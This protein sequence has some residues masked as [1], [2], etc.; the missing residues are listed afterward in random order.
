MVLVRFV[1]G[2]LLASTSQF[3]L[4]TVPVLPAPPLA[5]VESR[6]LIGMNPEQVVSVLGRPHSDISNNVSRAFE[7]EGKDCSRTVFFKKIDG[8]TWSVGSYLGF[9]ENLK[10]IDP[11]KCLQQ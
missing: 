1:T 3:S 9:D 8:K 6:R 11:S 4:P 10:P 5:S 2:A 7:Y